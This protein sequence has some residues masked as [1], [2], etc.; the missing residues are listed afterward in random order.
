MKRFS[1]IPAIFGVALLLP[2]AGSA[3]PPPNIILVLIDDMG[4][5]DFSCFGNQ[6]ARTPNIDRMAAEGI[7]FSQFYVNSPICSPSRCA[8]TTGQ[9]PQRWLSKTA[10][11][12]SGAA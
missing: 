3:T 5:G 7:R 10:P 9:Y 4:W 8:I 12:T 6:A 2:V 11:R 1:M